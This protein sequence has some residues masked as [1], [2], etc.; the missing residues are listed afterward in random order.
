MR[1]FSRLI[2][3]VSIILVV[4]SESWA[5]A[6]DWPNFRGPGMAN[7]TSEKGFMTTWSAPPKVVWESPVGSAFSAFAIV[8]DRAF[9]CGTK[10]KQQVLYCFDAKTGKPVWERPFEAELRER[11]GGDGTRATPT[12]HD[13]RVYV[14][15]AIGTLICVD[16]ARGDEI[17]RKQFSHK[18]NW[19]YS[20]SVLIEGDLAIASGGGSDGGMVAF[21]RKTGRQVW[22]CGDDPAGYGSPFPFDFKGRRYVF[23]LLAKVG[24]V[25]EPATGR[26]VLRIPWTTDY[27]VNATTPLYHEGHLFLSTGYDT[28]CALFKLGGEGDRLTAT[29]VWRNKA[30]LTKF[31]SCVLKDG[32]IYGGD[33]RNTFCV[34]FMT[35][36]ERWSANRLAN[37]SVLLAGD[38]LIVLSEKGRLMIAP[39]SPD[40][41]QPTA[42]ADVLSGRCWTTPVLAGGLLYVRN[43][44]KAVCVDLRAPAAGG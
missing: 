12:V 26:E 34:E 5:A 37:A 7:I 22:R 29:E 14:L 40:G 4:M 38:Q 27:D 25:A 36:K 8:G 6:A 15:G 42:E 44:E 41:F 9:T 13:G 21:D 35:G 11:Q 2:R 20:G 16:A 30:L 33:Q 24:L 28:G 31:T 1:S 32:F 17:W 19:G 43:L 23:C 39:P 10:D 3:N 18:P